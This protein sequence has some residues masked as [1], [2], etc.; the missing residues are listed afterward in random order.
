ME[1]ANKVQTKM[2]HDD[3][4]VNESR[5]A[6]IDQLLCTR[7]SL[8]HEQTEELER[9][10]A[11][12]NHTS[13]VS[14]NIS[15]NL[16]K[17]PLQRLPAELWQNILVLASVLWEGGPIQVQRER[18][19]Q[20][21]TFT[22]VSAS[23]KGSIISTPSFW[24]SIA[25]YRTGDSAAKVVTGLILSKDL[26]IDLYLD[27]SLPIEDILRQFIG[28]ASHRIR[29]L[30]IRST[31]WN[32]PDDNSPSVKT[33]LEI[34]TELSALEHIYSYLPT[35]W[36]DAMNEL[37]TRSQ[38]IHTFS[39]YDHSAT[40]LQIQFLTTPTTLKTL[41]TFSTEYSPDVILPYL[42]HLQALQDVAFHLP[43]N[44]KDD[45][46]ITRL[47]VDKQVS[48]PM[49]NCLNWEELSFH[50]TPGPFLWDLLTPLSSTLVLLATTLYWDMVP[51]FL[52]LLISMSNLRS[53]TISLPPLPDKTMNITFEKQSYDDVS[54]ID[55]LS[56]T[57]SWSPSFHRL[58]ST[59]PN[60]DEDQVNYDILSFMLETLTE[61]APFVR[62]LYLSGDPFPSTALLYA[63]S[64]RRLVKFYLHV[65]KIGV[66]TFPL[67]TL[68]KVEN[69]QASS[70]A[71]VS[72]LHCPVA[73]RL[74]VAADQR[75]DLLNINTWSNLRTLLVEIPP[76]SWKGISLPRVEEISVD[77]SLHF[78]LD[79]GGS[80]LLE[81]LALRIDSFPCLS[82]LRLRKFPEWDILFLM[83][84]RRNFLQS[85]SVTAP[86]KHIDS[87]TLPFR[88]ASW[89]V[90]PLIDRLGDQLS[91]RPINYELSHH[92]IAPI[93][94]D[95]DM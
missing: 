27:I 63:A 90:K 45:S 72:S 47:Q 57:C 1:M 58:L 11:Q 4:E 73:M 21:L 22:M 70:M 68:E 35:K 39:N 25:V 54:Y 89:I 28:P 84:E 48:H 12:Y 77:S 42:Q 71:L 85:N 14:K 6:Q 37:I 79:E 9:L 86:C 46:N 16:N 40:T 34:L 67:V 41:T 61:L 13:Q 44:Q 43:F 88:P 33:L 75:S 69:I 80:S 18:I 31:T 62:R 50:Q 17:D 32:T 2:P 78:T 59:F 93:Y 64:L 26:P 7:H 94:F 83:L 60:D 23:W 8:S 74:G 66:T 76:L 3:S 30:H 87:I 36:N 10:C 55:N 5:M 29:T 49:V 95:R 51:K 20:I 92:A 24:T 38:N 82:R 19:D 65:T 81:E 56:I 52:S 53:L 15:P 91:V